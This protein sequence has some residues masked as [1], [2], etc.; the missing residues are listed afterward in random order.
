MNEPMK[1]LAIIIALPLLTA[2]SA[3]ATV[4]EPPITYD[5]WNINQFVQHRLGPIV[6]FYGPNTY[7]FDGTFAAD[8]GTGPVGTFSYVGGVLSWDMPYAYATWVLL[9]DLGIAWRVHHAYWHKGSVEIGASNHV[10]IMGHAKNEIPD[11]GS[12]AALLAVAL[13]GLCCLRRVA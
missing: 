9:D 10:S 12:T 13:I 6:E 7:Y 8:V 3:F 2:G 5:D 4:L 11:T 1:K